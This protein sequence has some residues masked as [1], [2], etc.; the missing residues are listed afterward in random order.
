M[1]SPTNPIDRVLPQPLQSHFISKDG[2]L[3]DDRTGKEYKIVIKSDDAIVNE[4]AIGHIDTCLEVL[5]AL[6]NS[7]ASPTELHGLSI[8]TGGVD[9]QKNKI[10]FGSQLG[11]PDIK[12]AFDV[13][14]QKL[15]GEANLTTRE[16]KIVLQEVKGPWQTFIQTLIG[17]IHPEHGPASFIRVM[18]E[19]IIRKEEKEEES[20]AKSRGNN[21][22]T[23]IL[24]EAG[25]MT[26]LV[27]RETEELQELKELQEQLDTLYTVTREDLRKDHEAVQRDATVIQHK[28]IIT[29]LHLIK[30][31][32]KYP[33]QNKFAE[34]FNQFSAFLE[35]H[36]NPLYKTEDIRSLLDLYAKD[37]NDIKQLIEIEEFHLFHHAK[38]TILEEDSTQLKKSELA[39]KELELLKIELNI[40]KIQKDFLSNKRRSLEK[41]PN[42]DPSIE[43]ERKD[44]DAID[45]IDIELTKKQTHITLTIQEDASILNAQRLLFLESIPEYIH[46]QDEDKFLN[47]FS[48]FLKT[49]K[50]SKDP[51][52]GHQEIRV[53][54]RSFIKDVKNSKQLVDLEMVQFHL[55]ELQE[56]LKKENNST[57]LLHLKYEIAHTELYLL[58]A[59]R[60]ILLQLR[61]SLLDSIPKDRPLSEAEKTRINTIDE[62]YA[63]LSKSGEQMYDEEKG[64]KKSYIETLK[65][66]EV[67][68][69]KIVEKTQ[70]SSLQGTLGKKILS[71]SAKSLRASEDTW[72][73]KGIQKIKSTGETIY[74]KLTHLLG[75]VQGLR[76][77]LGTLKTAKQKL[78][79]EIR[80]AEQEISRLERDPVPSSSDREADIN[81]QKQMISELQGKALQIDLQRQHAVMTKIGDEIGS[82]RYFVN[83][84]RKNIQTKEKDLTDDRMRLKL[85]QL[86]LNPP[87]NY[88]EEIQK[89]TQNNKI[90]ANER[91]YIPSK[92]DAKIEELER[93]LRSAEKRIQDF[94][95]EISIAKVEIKQANK[96]IKI[97]NERYYKIM[98][99]YENDW[100][101]PTQSMIPW[102]QE[103]FISAISFGMITH[104]LPPHP[105]EIKVKKQYIDIGYNFCEAMEDWAEE[106]KKSEVPASVYWGDLVQEFY[107]WAYKHPTA[108]TQL[109]GDIAL[110]LSIVGQANLANTFL[111]ALKGK[112]FAFSVLK[113]IG[114]PDAPL[115]EDKKEMKFRAMADLCRHAPFIATAAHS[116][117][118]MTINTI[119]AGASAGPMGALGALFSSY[120][121]GA[122]NTASTKAIR[123]TIDSI[124]GPSGANIL[125]K[126][127]LMHNTFLTGVYID[128]AVEQ[129]SLA[130]AKQVATAYQA[131][132][133]P[134]LFE[135]I[136]KNKVSHWW[137]TIKFASTPLEKLLRATPAIA[138]TS[139]LG[140]I[141]LVLTVGAP[142]TWV[143][144]G[145]LATPV[146][147][148]LLSG[149]THLESWLDFAFS[150]TITRIKMEQVEQVLQR[151]EGKINALAENYKEK[152]F[153][154]HTLPVLTPVEIPK[155]YQGIF[156]NWKTN[157]ETQQ[158]IQSIESEYTQKLSQKT[159]EKEDQLALQFDRDWKALRSQKKAKWGD[160]P[161]EDWKECQRMKD[162]EKSI[163]SKKYNI[164]TPIMR[165]VV[166]LFT[167]EVTLKDLS[168]QVKEKLNFNED[169]A[170]KDR[171]DLQEMIVE[172]CVKE[173]ISGLID[174]WLGKQLQKAA[175]EQFK[176]SYM[177]FKDEFMNKDNLE[178][179]FIETQK[180]TQ[181]EINKQKEKLTEEGFEWVPATKEKNMTNAANDAMKKQTIAHRKGLPASRK[182]WW[183]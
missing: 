116:V 34:V 57:N 167:S 55:L 114:V 174:K 12:D 90:I 45:K 125:Q 145:A 23:R 39:I 175:R 20:R 131:F 50:D 36:E 144:V 129:E 75:K 182:K 142:F 81:K 146:A 111:S 127:R 110:T 87:A 149:Y 51:I 9:T 13:S 113:E 66:Q 139:V 60:K 5:K 137:N 121:E 130:M 82:L 86:M 43:T 138:T 84:A 73:P 47:Q 48:S 79:K 62:T 7:S 38:K 119:A 26:G 30:Y 180:E 91:Q 102:M 53:L 27:P 133:H 141:T 72:V 2:H 169:P 64:S 59:Q 94:N 151:K 25:K 54:L 165:E 147:Y 181:Q 172:N 148:F 136:V 92:G 156:D 1:S 140:L 112:V 65:D 150:A 162:F 78:K 177:T 97:L 77:T 159:K 76:N 88:D 44:I 153:E 158:K 63:A 173:I 18:I 106:M 69:D 37:D 122:L 118:N 157:Q 71:T 179:A 95:H 32:K 16:R 126:A 31:Y 152:L 109:A 135:K 164:R 67:P 115:I 108:A 11:N 96:R 166:E 52:Y 154:A 93:R 46:S 171:S 123:D 3:V 128:S 49:Y 22:V 101:L 4:D 56:K 170:L 163:S 85:Y 134:K 40:I 143:M 68:F 104:T 178:T 107:E 89:L 15:K 33:D 168:K 160:L 24:A 183:H 117:K 132:K 35:K 19:S 28:Q 103:T 100:K 105:Q 74:D 17:D 80:E 176:A 10:A 124:T 42:N 155:Q 98:A 61:E 29:L 70:S 14:L 58:S 8:S 21:Y 6:E 41:N 99:K 120:A 161:E 83:K